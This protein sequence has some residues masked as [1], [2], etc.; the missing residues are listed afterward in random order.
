MNILYLGSFR[1]PNYDAAAPRVLSIARAM[2]INGHSVSFISWGG[3]YRE[4]DL[5][6][7]G[8]YR[9]DGMEYIITGELDA[10]GS[11]WTRWKAKKN[12]GKR[13]FRLL[14]DMVQLPDVIIMYNAGSGLSKRMMHFCSTRKMYLV[15]DITEWF[16]NRE[17]RVTD[18][19]PNHIN[20]TRIQHKV[21]NKILI[22]S[23]LDRYYHSSHN[24]VIPATCDAQEPKWNL[25]TENNTFKGISFIYA[26]NPTMKDKLHTAINVIQKL[27][28][29][30]ESLQ[31]LILGI[32]REDYLKRYGKLLS[33]SRLSENI[34]FLGRVSQD[35]VPLYYM[36]ADFMILLRDNTRKSQAGFPTKFA[37]SMTSGTPVIANLTSDLGKY[38]KS[39]YNGEIVTSPS[40][41]AL[42]MTLK[43]KIL[44]LTRPEIEEMKHNAKLT[45]KHS[46]DY[47]LYANEV[48]SFLKGL[49]L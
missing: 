22:S 33:C 18:I 10:K 4:S 37:E 41:D 5:C 43:R 26:G 12:R 40:E 8:K 28:N 32:N 1:L 47:R 45:G 7:D 34:K 36:M 6:N 9:I 13:T 31:F 38:L 20:M 48:N 2:A 19:V 44:P 27:I 11:L 39:G 3:R 35:D 42:Y 23:F 49:K 21:P 14:E 15:N 17:I 29:E 16:S 25:A 24:I 46:F 30:G